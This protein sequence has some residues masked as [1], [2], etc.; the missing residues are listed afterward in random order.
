MPRIGNI[1]SLEPDL[2]ILGS[3]IFGGLYLLA[4]RIMG[5]SLSQMKLL[6]LLPYVITVIVL[7]ITSIMDKKENQPPAALGTNYF[8]EER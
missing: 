3:V 6:R 1:Y 7:I 2:S 4:Q 5:I 8:R